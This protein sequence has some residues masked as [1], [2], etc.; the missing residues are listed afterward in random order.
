MVDLQRPEIVP[1]VGFAGAILQREIDLPGMSVSSSHVPSGCCLDRSSSIAPVRRESGGSDLR[2]AATASCSIGICAVSAEDRFAGTRSRGNVSVKLLSGQVELHLLPAQRPG[3]PHQ[4]T[5]FGVTDYLAA[6]AEPQLLQDAKRPPVPCA[7]GR[8][9]AYASR[10]DGSGMTDLFERQLAERLQAHPLPEEIPD[11]GIRSVRL[12]E[13]IRRRRIA[14]VVLVL[15]VL[16][17]IPA[18]AGLWRRA[19]GTDD[20][21]VVTRPSP[22]AQTSAG[23]IMVHLYPRDPVGAAPEVSTVRGRSVWLPSGETVKLPDGEFGSIAEYGSRLAWL[24]RT[25]G[26]IRLNVS[27]ERLPIATNGSEV[28][29]AEPGPN[30]SVMVRTKAGPVILTSGGMLVAPSQAELHTNRMVATADDIWVENGGRAL[31]VRMADLERG[32]FNG[33]PI[34]NGGGWSSVTL[35]PIV[36]W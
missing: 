2:R 13:R 30:G 28:T 3:Q 18:A 32:S 36:S 11:L 5:A 29:G 33:Q 26:E 21:P 22:S 31:R 27:S 15:V 6:V 19:A 1:P 9:E 20:P 16:L 35:A 10:L 24:T 4:V 25:G 14:A 12:G 8:P 7:D 34:R 23:P 17:M